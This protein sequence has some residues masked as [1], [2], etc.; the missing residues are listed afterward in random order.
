MAG[1]LPSRAPTCSGRAVSANPINTDA[2]PL[3]PVPI[4]LA[5]GD[6]P[7]QVCEFHI[8][9]ELTKA[10][11]RVLAQIRKRLAETKPKLP[12]GR[13]RNSAEG[14]RRHRQAQ[15]IQQ[16]VSALFE[17]RQLFVRHHLSAA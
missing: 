12:R 7:H 9:K 2:S 6:I 4:L 5:L 1:E 14:Q 10:V 15:A 3:Y 16:R 13:P 8:L 11:L 17:H